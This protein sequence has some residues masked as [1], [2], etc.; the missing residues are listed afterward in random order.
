MMRPHI[1][2]AFILLAGTLGIIVQSL[3][4]ELDSGAVVSA[5]KT[6]D[7]RWGLRVGGAGTASVTQTQPVCLEISGR[8]DEQVNAGYDSLSVLDQEAVGRA[9]VSVSPQVRL[10]VEDRWSVA[11]A[12]LR[13][14]RT[15][16]VAGHA[17]AGFV[18]AVTLPIDE[19][20]A[21]PQTQWFAPGMIYGG[22]EH[23]PDTASGAEEK[24]GAIRLGYW[25]PGTEGEVT[26]AGNTDPGG[27]LHKWQR[28]YRPLK[29]GRVQ[30][31]EVSF[32]FGRAN[33]FADSSRT[34]WRPAA[35]TV[36]T[37]AELPWVAT[38]QLNGIFGL[39][40][41]DGDMY[42]ELTNVPAKD[43]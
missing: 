41:L 5:I 42:H 21:W 40:D 15:L 12:V 43:N 4:A 17:P 27:H 24:G 16:R 9:E 28:R 31:Y 18:S 35:D 14:Q 6:P 13:V 19:K 25:F 3:A 33:S 29:D 26:Y 11:G 37:A 22:F 23:L 34:A 20:L 38:S 32:R 30:Q 10:A 7:G 36:C 1:L 39:L 8:A 2:R